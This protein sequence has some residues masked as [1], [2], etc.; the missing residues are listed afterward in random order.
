M[1]ARM[2]SSADRLDVKRKL[3]GLRPGLLQAL[4]LLARDAG[5]SLDAL[6]EEAFTDLLRKYHRPVSLKEALKESA[7]LLPANDDTPPQRHGT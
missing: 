7:R 5:T 4:E 3:V 1:L 6:A 2:S